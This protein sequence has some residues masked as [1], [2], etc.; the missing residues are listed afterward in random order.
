MKL[1]RII[2]FPKR[3]KKKKYKS[4]NEDQIE[5]RNTINLNCRIKLKTNKFFT[6]R[7]KKIEIKKIKINLKKNQYML[8]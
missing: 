4:N 2:I 5:K 3:L 6:N 8:H 7:L 1:K